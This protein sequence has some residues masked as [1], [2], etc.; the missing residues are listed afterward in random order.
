[1]NTL[2][3]KLTT[4]Q[5]LDDL[6]KLDA[7]TEERMLA[8]YAIPGTPTTVQRFREIAAEQGVTT[9]EILS[10]ALAALEAQARR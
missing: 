4:E 2:P 5:M 3:Q 8:R 7:W 1:M 6:A 9:E 10:R